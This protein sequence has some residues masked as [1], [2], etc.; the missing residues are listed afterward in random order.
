MIVEKE[1][2]R[3]TTDILPGSA[4][5]RVSEIRRASHRAIYP[6]RF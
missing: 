4:A 1:R 3:C 6:M 5:V 2:R